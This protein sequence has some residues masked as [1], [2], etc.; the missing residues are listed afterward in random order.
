MKYSRVSGCSVKTTNSGK[1]G[2]LMSLSWVFLDYCG[3][4]TT[5]EI[6]G[7]ALFEKIIAHE[8]AKL[9]LLGFLYCTVRSDADQ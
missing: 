1:T 3:R 9:L 4:G 5:L 8:E 7:V 6:P 2:L